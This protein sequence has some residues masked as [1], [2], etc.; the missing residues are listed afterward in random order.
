MP[1]ET[2]TT[3]GPGGSRLGPRS[4]VAWLRA[5]PLLADALLAGLLA[6]V[7]LVALAAAGR[8]CAGDCDPRGAAVG[9]VLATTLPLVWR[10]RFPFAVS[11]VTGMATAAYGFAHYPDLAMPIAIGGVVGMYSVAAWGS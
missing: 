7:S 1:E 9:L 10:R 2:T 4:V 3:G 6:V 8:E 11:L 5:R